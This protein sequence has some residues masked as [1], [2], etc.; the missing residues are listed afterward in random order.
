MRAF[1]WRIVVGLYMHA[2]DRRPSRC[3]SAISGELDEERGG[4][5]RGRGD[6][7]R[8]TISTSFTFPSLNLT[9]S[10]VIRWFYAVSSNNGIGNWIHRKEPWFIFLL[11]RHEAAPAEHFAASRGPANPHAN[12]LMR[13]AF[14]SKSWT[15]I[16]SNKCVHLTQWLSPDKSISSSSFI[17]V[18]VKRGTASL[19]L[20]HCT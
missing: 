4:E 9:S 19:L 14:C 10:I 5:L 2:Y 15:M 18:R 3:T 13:L 1:A 8:E 7:A 12:D 16:G 17:L 6:T 11:Y 20:R